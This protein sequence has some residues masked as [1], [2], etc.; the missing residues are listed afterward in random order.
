MSFSQIV[1]T[2]IVLPLQVAAI[3]A[4]TAHVP[5]QAQLG[6]SP[7]VIEIQKDR[8]RTP[9]AVL[10][11]SNPTTKPI[12]ARVY[13]QPFTYDQKGF[14]LLPSSQWDLAPYLQF[15][16]REFIIPPGVSRRVRLTAQLPANLP[17]GE[18]RTAILTEPVEETPGQG[19][20]IGLVKV[21]VATTLYVRKGALKPNLTAGSASFRP[22][23]KWLQLPISNS[24]NSSVR[25]LAEWTLKRGTTVLRTGTLPESTVIAGGQSTLMLNRFDGQPL[26]LES[27]EYQLSGNLSWIQDG[28]RTVLPFQSTLVVPKQKN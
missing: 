27:G 26:I 9:A 15:S 6:V 3:A 7:L 23:Q 19:T 11:V 8:G 2:A 22:D 13:T 24:G 16:P 20:Q 28:K 5:V 21:R 12:R 17:E 4:L 18:Y 10:S 14:Q 1:K 25:P